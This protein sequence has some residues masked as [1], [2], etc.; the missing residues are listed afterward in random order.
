MSEESYGYDLRESRKAVQELYPVLRDAHGNVID[1]N[2][3]LIANP[4][5]REETLPWITTRTQLTLARIIA[6]THRRSVSREERAEQIGELAQALVEE[7]GVPR[8]EL[9]PEICS[10]TTF[11]DRYIRDLLPD[12]Y[13]L[14]P[15]VGPRPSVE[16]S[17]TQ[18]AE[19]MEEFQQRL[20][21]LG[22]RAPEEEADLEP[23]EY[24][25]RYFQ[26]YLH[27]DEDFLNWSLRR[28]YDLTEEEAQELIDEQKESMK[29][30]R[31][32]PPERAPR[33]EPSRQTCRCPLCGRDGADK[34]LI[35]ANFVED[36]AMAQMTLFDFITEAFKE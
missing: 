27:P 8:E 4:E 35:L 17:S 12:E 5:W 11:S 2:Q 31:P 33:Y 15:G 24:V 29:P 7:E 28:R 16:L 25:T 3:R 1:G 19:V 30:S 26:R 21:D 23:S 20:E 34:L 18:D 13:K 6:N 9:I 22:I 14:R 32:K 36:T 10:L